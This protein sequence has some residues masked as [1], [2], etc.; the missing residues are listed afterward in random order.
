[1]AKIRKDNGYAER[2]ELYIGGMELAN[3]FGE[4]TDHM[5]H[6]QRFKRDLLR[7]SLNKKPL[8]KLDEPFLNALNSGMPPSAGMAIGIERLLMVLNNTDKIENLL[9]FSE[10]EV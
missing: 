4:L 10:K 7:R 9:C 1:M 3:G 8:I 5:E 6:R 2:A